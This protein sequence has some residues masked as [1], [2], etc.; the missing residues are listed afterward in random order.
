MSFWGEKLVDSILFERLS[1]DLNSCKY[2]ENDIC[3][4]YVNINA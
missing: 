2:A 4:E 3:D 1:Y